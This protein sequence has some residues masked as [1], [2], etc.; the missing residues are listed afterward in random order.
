MEDFDKYRVNGR[1][2]IDKAM[3]EKSI[4]Y[5]EAEQRGARENK[6]WFN[7]YSYMYK[8]VY[9]KTYEDYAELIAYEIAKLLGIKCAQYDL[10]IY[11][12][13][14]GGLLRHMSA[15]FGCVCLPQGGFYGI[16]T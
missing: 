1:I 8:D 14:K 13:S 9:E 11:N 5:D 7:K 2:N 6:F 4:R 10:A 15:A 16:D 12:T 3:E